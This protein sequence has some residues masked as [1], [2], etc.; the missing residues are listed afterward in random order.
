MV[1]LI[2]KNVRKV[3]YIKESYGI[4]LGNWKNLKRLEI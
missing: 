1:D 3:Y 4:I 2:S